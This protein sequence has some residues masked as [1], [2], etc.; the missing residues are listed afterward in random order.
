MAP[1]G[2]HRLL[3]DVLGLAGIV[4]DGE[5]DPEEAL[6]MRDHGSLEGGTAVLVAGG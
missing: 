1:G 2:E 3:D 5:G 4:D 6:A